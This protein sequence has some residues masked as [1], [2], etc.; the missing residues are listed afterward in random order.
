MLRAIRLLC[1]MIA[2]LCAPASV[3]ADEPSVVVHLL[4]TGAPIPRVDRFGPSTL[5]QAGG[6]RLLFDAGRGVSQRLWQL[7]VSLGSIDAVFLTHLHSD[8][9]VGLPDLWLTGWL[10]PEYGQ[11]K[12]DL[13]LFGPVGTAALARSLRE[14]FSADIGYRTAKE[15]LPAEGVDLSVMEIQGEQT[16]FERNGVKVTPFEVD[17][18]GAKPAYGF[19]IEASGKTI[20]LSGDTRFNENLMRQAK[21]AD[22]L[23]HEVVSAPVALRATPF[24]QRQFDYHTS[25]SDLARLLNEARPTMAVLSHF[26]LLGNAAHPAP[27]ADDVMRE[28]RDSGYAGP[29]TAGV[30]LMRIDVGR[31]VAIVAPK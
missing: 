29:L 9:L 30:D 11:R 19:R 24:V 18:G 6:L 28:I 16:I 15:G 3:R 10:Q 26:V 5:V 7:R 14:G 13:N 21:G 31:D 8:H 1:A 25:P 2:L 12:T 23:I 17:H 20:V 27:T 22:L 4:G